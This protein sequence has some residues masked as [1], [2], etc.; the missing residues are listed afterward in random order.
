MAEVDRWRLHNP[1]LI[2]QE[3][4]DLSSC[5]VWHEVFKSAQDCQGIE[6]G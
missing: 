6:A 5:L 1:P 3:L 4:S 2:T